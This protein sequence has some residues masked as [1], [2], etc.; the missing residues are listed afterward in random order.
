MRYLPVLV[1]FVSSVAHAE[2]ETRFS[3]GTSPVFPAL[4]GVGIEA[5]VMPPGH[6]RYYAAAFTFAL[7]SWLQRSNSDEGWT[8]RDSGGAVGA[9]YFLDA[10]GRGVFFGLVAEVQNHHD[11][12]MGMTENALE[13][14]VAAELG[15]RWMPWRGLFVTPRLL[16]VVPVYMSRD[17]RLGNASF[18]EAPV[19]PVPLLSTGWQF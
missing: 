10:A 7:P 1:V 17:R 2:P 3:V 11:D 16:A 9:D 14:G 18:D 8:I 5:D 19:R 15:Y 4:E 13:I 12:R 6:L